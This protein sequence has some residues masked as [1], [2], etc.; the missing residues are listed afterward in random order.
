MMRS[1]R[2]QIRL[3]DRKHT[4]V[5]GESQDEQKTSMKKTDFSL[6]KELKVRLDLQEYGLASPLTLE[7]VPLNDVPYSRYD[8]WL[9]DIRAGSPYESNMP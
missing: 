9:R 6:E 5:C 2:D 4:G 7:P 1:C 3:H 8:E